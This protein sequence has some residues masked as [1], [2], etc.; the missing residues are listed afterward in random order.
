MVATI[1]ACIAA[2]GT[3]HRLSLDKQID[4]SWQ[5]S[6]TKGCISGWAHAISDAWIFKAQLDNRLFRWKSHRNSEWELLPPLS[7][8]EPY[9]GIAH[10][11][12]FSYEIKFDYVLCAFVAIK[13]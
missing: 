10:N 4:G 3:E 12:K 9:S 13:G 6:E 8:L 11:D 1:S 5:Q 2:K 7:G